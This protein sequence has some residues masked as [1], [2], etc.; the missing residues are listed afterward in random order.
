M[1]VMTLDIP[2]G[3]TLGVIFCAV[4]I[5]SIIYG[6]TC[7]QGF[8]YYRSW[9]AREDCRFLRAAM[10][11]I[12]MIDTLHQVTILHL[13]YFYLINHFGDPTAPITSLPWSGPLEILFQAITTCLFNCFMTLRLWRLSHSRALTAISAMCTL[14]TAVTSIAYAIR[15]YF[16]HSLLEGLVAIKPHGVAAIILSIVTELTTSI[17]VAYFLHKSRTGLPNTDDFITKLIVLTISTGMITTPFNIA[18]LIAYLA[19]QDNLFVLFFNFLLAKLYP[20]AFLTTLNVRDYL[21][22]IAL[23]AHDLESIAHISRVLVG[24]TTMPP[25]YPDS[26]GRGP[27]RT[28]LQSS[29]AEPPYSTTSHTRTYE[30]S[31]D[32]SPPNNLYNIMMTPL[33]TNRCSRQV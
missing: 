3:S 30:S 31:E 10:F 8:L 13:G 32:P 21:R 5:S 2:L 27:S 7:I 4:C 28:S 15:G 29:R 22:H 1:Q 25:H 16:Y 9:R 23:E 11:T 12:V 26:S 6:T 19:S 17:S 18:S 24:S 33:A 20:T 14:G